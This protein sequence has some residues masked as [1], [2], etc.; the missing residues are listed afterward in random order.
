MS[1]AKA[2]IFYSR[3]YINFVAEQVHHLQHKWTRH[4]ELLFN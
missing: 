3:N 4:K 1:V 2:E